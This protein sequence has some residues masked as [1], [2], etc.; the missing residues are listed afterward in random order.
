MHNKKLI[1]DNDL[2]LKSDD[3]T[4]Y[5]IRVDVSIVEFSLLIHS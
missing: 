2:I 1:L 5:I 3:G 4:V